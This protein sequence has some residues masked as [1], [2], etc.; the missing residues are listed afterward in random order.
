MAKEATDLSFN[1][2]LEDVPRD[3][4]LVPGEELWENHGWCVR[5][6]DQGHDYLLWSGIY[7]VHGSRYG[8]LIDGDYRIPQ[9]IFVHGK[10]N[11][12]EKQQMNDND[13]IIWG[14]HCSSEEYY[15]PQELVW[16]CS[17]EEGVVWEVG[18]KNTNLNHQG[19]A[20]KGSMVDWS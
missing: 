14:T 11:S 12:E 18:G 5:G 3:H 9:T 8:Y 6:E 4:L 13:F 10:F 20:F 2:S 7:L 15:P 17:P 16:M 1:V 19:G